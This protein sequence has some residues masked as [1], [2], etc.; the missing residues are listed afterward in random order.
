MSDALEKLQHKLET[1]Q[2]ALAEAEARCVRQEAEHQA[3]IK[4]AEHTR[5][6]IEQAHQGWMSALDPAEQFEELHRWHD[7]T[8]GREEHI[9]ELRQEVNELLGQT[10]Q[11]LRVTSVL[12]FN[13]QSRYKS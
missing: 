9:L 12:N 10:G 6:Q 1:A 2:C 4:Q 7:V 8:L 3:S 13:G 11:Q 5:K